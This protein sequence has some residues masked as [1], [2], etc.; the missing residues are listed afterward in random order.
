MGE[1]K[2]LPVD[3]DIQ[4]VLDMA[5]ERGKVLDMAKIKYIKG[6]KKHGALDIDKDPRNFNQEAIEELLDSMV[7]IAAEV[8]RLMKI[9]AQVNRLVEDKG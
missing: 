2:D 4:F 9:E 5:K 7:Y 1:R 6:E 3:E 8:L